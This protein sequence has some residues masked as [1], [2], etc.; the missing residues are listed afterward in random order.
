MIANPAKTKEVIIY[1][2]KKITKDII[3]V[4]TVD[5]RPIE[6]TDT[7]K[8]LGVVFTSNLSW[9]SHVLHILGKVSKRYIISP[10]CQTGHAYSNTER[11]MA[12]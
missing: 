9:S 1:F 8:L 10:Q 6:R 3:P 12:Q 5:S 7:F 2:G 4:V 11:M